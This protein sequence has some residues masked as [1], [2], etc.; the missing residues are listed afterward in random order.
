M[1]KKKNYKYMHTLKCLPAYYVL[2]Q[3]I[4]YASQYVGSLC[5]TL[6]QIRGEQIKSYNWRKSKGWDDC[7]ADYDYMKVVID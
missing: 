2:N 5:D 4:V 1:N 3:Q 7:I 6:K